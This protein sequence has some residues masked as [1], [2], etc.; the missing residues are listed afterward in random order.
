MSLLDRQSDREAIDLQRWPD[1]APPTPAPV[2]S[3][4]ARMIL[5]Q[6]AAR[7]GIRVNLADGRAYGPLNGPAM[8]VRD[9]RAFFARLGKDGKI[10]FGESY[11]AREWEAD[12]LIDVLVALA[13]NPRS[14]IPRSLQFFRRWYESRR[15]GYEENDR[16]GSARNIS[17]HYDLSN[18]LFATFLDETMTYSSALFSNDSA[19]LA[20]AQAN[21]IERLLDVA[22]VCA[23]SRVLEVGTGWGELA[24][25]AA[26]RGARVTSVTLSR[27]QASLA[28]QRIADAGLGE[29]VD[30][31]VED[32]RDVTGLYDAVV[33]VEMIE[34]VGE[35]W[36][37]TYF[38][39]LERRLAPGGRIGLQSILM[40]HE[41]LEATKRSWTWIH[42]YIFPGGI[43]PSE[44]AIRDTVRAHTDLTQIDQVNFGASYA[45]TL[46]LWREQFLRSLRDVADLG[47]DTTFCRMWEFYLAYCESGFQ[48]GYLDVAQYVFARG[49]GDEAT[50]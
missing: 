39:T 4:I 23:G 16:A 26:R 28:R 40:G 12:A 31:R 14:L 41:S 32:Y 47:F 50:S 33:S 10:G 34:A 46:R 49:S 11:M 27:E 1:L 45:T 3:A 35:R 43:I 13:R 17:R 25:R 2:R 18:G 9:P 19:S 15:P 48:S 36:W 44:Q 20:Q 7:A 42:K 38:S 6:V 29:R 8:T 24:L 5:R 37:P 22:G 21:K 30:I